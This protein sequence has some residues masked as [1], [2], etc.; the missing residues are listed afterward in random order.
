M[1]QVAAEA[2]I[3]RYITLPGQALSY[4]VGERVI[5]RARENMDRGWGFDL[6]KFH[7]AFLNCQGPL[8]L[9]EECIEDFMEDH[10]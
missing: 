6:K 8:D 10:H 9:L 2:E 1:S 4:K 3:D 5:R 7:T